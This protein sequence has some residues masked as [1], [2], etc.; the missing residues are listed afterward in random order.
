[1]TTNEST[2]TNYSNYYYFL[3]NVTYDEYKTNNPSLNVSNFFANLGDL[4]LIPLR[5][6]TSQFSDCGKSYTVKPFGYTCTKLE[7]KESH[8]TIKI[9]GLIIMGIILT[10]PGI[11]CKGLSMISD[12]VRYKHKITSQ[13]GI[14]PDEDRIMED[15][16]R[17]RVGLRK[18][19]SIKRPEPEVTKTADR[20]TSEAN[21]IDVTPADDILDVNPADADADAD[22]RP[23]LRQAYGMPEDSDED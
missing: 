2:A 14:T 8:S 6:A 12:E 21:T 1:M 4:C 5:A 15:G 3:N 20:K 7:N 18:L 19:G 9:V 23:S 13:A 17:E 11:I 10:V 16:F 22:V